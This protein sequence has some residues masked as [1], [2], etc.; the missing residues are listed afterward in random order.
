MS[1]W[2]A[3]RRSLLLLMLIGDVIAVT[4]GRGVGGASSTDDVIVVCSQNK[5]LELHPSQVMHRVTECA[6]LPGD[7]R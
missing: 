6:V 2:P 5:R 3:Q 1:V 7:L 4:A